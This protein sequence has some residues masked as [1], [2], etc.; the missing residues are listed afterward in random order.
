[1]TFD[2]DSPGLNDENPSPESELHDRVAEYVERLIAGEQIDPLDV[3][4]E[5]PGC[6]HEILEGLERFLALETGPEDEGNEVIG[7]L[8]HYAL[9]REVGRG[10]MGI[11]Y[12]ARDLT[13]RRSV[14]L[15]VLLASRVRD[16]RSVARFRRE[17]Q[18][19]ARLKH[20]NI[21]SV[22]GMGVSDDAPYFAMELVRGLTLRDLLPM[23]PSEETPVPN[24]SEIGQ[25]FPEASREDT[26]GAGVVPSPTGSSPSDRIDPWLLESHDA[27]RSSSRDA[28]DLTT[29][30]RIA[31][32]F[33]EVADA[34]HH[35]HSRGVVHRDLKP[36]NL[37][38]DHPD[39][40]ESGD[41]KPARSRLRILDFGLA[42]L[43]DADQAL[44][45][46]GAVI[47]TPLYMSP[48][49]ASSQPATARSDIYSLG[50]TLYELLTG[51]APCVGV[52][53]PDTMQS[54]L[55][56]DP[57]PIR[58]RNRSVPKS[59]D[60]ITLKCLRK[61][62]EKRYA[63]AEALAQDLRRFAR[64][65]PIEAQRQ[66]LF[67]RYAHRIRRHRKKLAVYAAVL[68]MLITSATLIVRQRNQEAR[69][70]ALEYHRRL[71]SAVMSLYQGHMGTR[72]SPEANV[73][74]GRYVSG[75]FVPDD[76]LV[77][78]SEDFAGSANAKW[79]ADLSILPDVDLNPIHQAIDE[80]R[81]V[82]ELDSNRPEAYYHLARALA[83]TKH[84]DDALNVLAELPPQATEFIPI[85]T[86]HATLLERDGKKQQAK[87]ELER[88]EQRSRDPRVRSWLT[89]HRA[90]TDEDWTREVAAY[91]EVLSTPR[92][93]AAFE[94]GLRIEALMG[95]GL[96]KMQLGK[97][98]EAAL[99][100][101]R[102]QGQWPALLGPRLL[103]GKSYL[104]DGKWSAAEAEFEDLVKT[105]RQPD[106]ATLGVAVAYSSIGQ[107]TPALTW[108]NRLRDP[109]LRSRTRASLFVKL[110]EWDE[111][112][113]SS[114]R[115]IELQP[116][117]AISQLWLGLSIFMSS[118]NEEDKA[119]G[120]AALVNACELNDELPVAHVLLGDALA[121]EGELERAM[122]SYARAAKL[123]PQ[124]PF[125]QVSLGITS[126]RHG[127][128]ERAL[129]AFREAFRL[130]PQLPTI[131]VH[132]E[133]LLNQRKREEFGPQ[134]GLFR[135]D[136]EA[137]LSSG[138]YHPFVAEVLRILARV[139]AR[140][141]SGTDL[142]SA[143]RYAEL[144]VERSGG[145]NTK[146]LVTL[147]EVEHQRGRKKEAVRRLEQAA[148]APHA[149]SSLSARLAD[150]RAELFPEFAS[151]E[152]AAEAVRAIDQVPLV[153]ESDVWSYFR[154]QKAPSP[155]LE[156]T[157]ANFDDSGWPR[158]RGGFGYG[159]SDDETV[160][161]EMRGAY[162]TVFIR[163]VFDVPEVESVEGV[164]FVVRV[165]DGCIAFLNG[166]EIAR[167][168]FAS[169]AP[170]AFDSL[171]FAQYP[172]PP[173]P[174]SF[175]VSP[176]LLKATGNVLAVLG[177]NHTL[178]SSDLSLRP[179]FSVSYLRSEARDA[180]F[181]ASLGEAA[182][183]SA[184]PTRRF[185][186]G[187]LT[188]RAGDANRALEIFSG[189]EP[190]YDAPALH[191]A[192]AQ[193]QELAGR[194][195]N[196]AAT[197]RAAIEASPRVDRTIWRRWLDVELNA[198][199]R[200]PQ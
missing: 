50:A 92:G 98:P 169:D 23:R 200:G 105:A 10:G 34:L 125:P 130:A 100:F 196:A 173:E 60:T 65:E 152:S 7:E 182:L 117:D 112:R 58:S 63:T 167:V 168:G 28:V 38:I 133:R 114:E 135:E 42:A 154:G 137:F 146:M 158:G 119:K 26:N 67:E 24:H 76:A 44:T 144:A 56:E 80:L 15:K 120:L 95:R 33:A 72:I 59:L 19:C 170:P 46:S 87:D 106:E 96:A 39:L 195:H 68:L 186:E 35:A 107:F 4:T 3:V 181:R 55:Y 41:A 174:W 132:I 2:S 31:S 199:G 148:K 129:E 83:Q 77:R 160:L 188:L 81:S 91:S 115:A 49:Q 175:G 37:I 97:F 16:E 108:A 165:D 75:I 184:A 155:K 147:A 40:D 43:D 127:N 109:L 198:L 1:M 136:L 70:S 178:N 141:P 103:V 17:A 93:D 172:E 116:N 94:I 179:N 145:R 162:S 140:D 163:R 190:S 88:A 191:L 110:G 64:G 78:A 32:S 8:G 51:R 157:Q 20:E 18:I 48:E 99:D 25:H 142:E 194:A 118:P 74:S 197:L 47:G 57:Q 185:V 166:E 21:V 69:H 176:S 121:K 128:P 159:D 139:L 29:A 192:V 73:K 52:T 161:S 66:T 85:A 113:R 14:A 79:D 45:V 86:L 189:I 134:L 126:V 143:Q 61:E 62:P 13:L 164:E 122:A 101:A 54:I 104:L 187:L 124:S 149:R 153:R 5:N 27:S 9:V 171:A 183:A 82:V 151:F 11:V 111:A 131:Y 138:E 30:R 180:K 102:A 84:R 90:V 177:A 123:D 150:Y 6:G 53:S 36:S 193:A 89:A 12:E 71:N 156:W 22:Y